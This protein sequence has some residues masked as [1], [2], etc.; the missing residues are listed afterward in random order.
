M[1][2]GFQTDLSSISSEIQTFV[3]VCVC[4][5]MSVYVSLSVSVCIC[6][7]MSLCVSVCVEN[8]ADVEW[9]SD[10]SQQHQQWN[11]DVAAAICCYESEIEEQTGR[12]WWTLTVCWWDGHSRLNDHVST[13]SLASYDETVIPDPII[14]CVLWRDGHSRPNDHVST[15]S[16]ASYDE[17]VIPDP[18]ITLV[19]HRLRLMTRRSFPTQWS[20]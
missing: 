17:T 19:H 10:R 11:T 8:G 4:V 15:S 20:R 13:S 1:L 9:F 12:A 3:S 2:N 16:L 6:V 18:M 7:C 5:C 14:A